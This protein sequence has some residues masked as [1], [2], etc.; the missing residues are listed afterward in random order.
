MKNEIGMAEQ[1]FGS[2]YKY[3]N[4]QAAMWSR[5]DMWKKLME[6]KTELKKKRDMDFVFSS[7][8]NEL[9]DI[10]GYL[11]RQIMITTDK[12]T[13][14]EEAEAKGCNDVIHDL[15]DKLDKRIKCLRR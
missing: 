5:R 13:D 3:V 12:A 10:Q 2:K 14:L 8:A 11:R 4:G 9:E 6:F 15:I 1:I 7:I